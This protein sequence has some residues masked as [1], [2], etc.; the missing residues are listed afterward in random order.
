MKISDVD[1]LDKRRSLGRD[2]VSVSLNHIINEVGI[3]LGHKAHYTKNG[4]VYTLHSSAQS[5]VFCHVALGF[6]RLVQ[7]APSTAQII[8]STRW[9]TDVGPIRIATHLARA[10]P[11]LRRREPQIDRAQQRCRS[12]V[13]MVLILLVILQESFSFSILKTCDWSVCR[14]LYI[15]LLC[16]FKLDFHTSEYRMDGSL[17]LSIDEGDLF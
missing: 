8:S 14:S 7:L 6:P 15:M 13:L 9:A 17:S 11:F 2:D 4:P 16:D 10:L 12:E 1:G 3:L 5:S